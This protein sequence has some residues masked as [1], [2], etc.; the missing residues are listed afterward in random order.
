MEAVRKRRPIWKIVLSFLGILA[1]TLIVFLIWLARLSE[2]RWHDMERRVQE[3]KAEYQARI[4]PRPVLR[5][6][7]TPGN[8]WDDY[9]PAIHKLK[10]IHREIPT[11]HE[12]VSRGKNAD[13]TAVESLLKVHGGL[14]DQLRKGAGR[15]EGQFGY[16]FEGVGFSWARFWS[17][18][19]HSLGHLAHLSICQTRLLGEAGKLHE[20]IALLLDVAQYARDLGENSPLN[21]LRDSRFNLSLLFEE[22]R[23]QLSPRIFPAEEAGFLKCGLEILDRFLPRASGMLHCQMIV[24]GAFLLSENQSFVEEL[25]IPFM[26]RMQSSYAF[27]ECIQLLS[28]LAEEESPWLEFQESHRRILRKAEK[29]WNPILP[30][31][32]PPLHTWTELREQRTQLRLLRLAATYRTTGQIPELEDPFGTKL[33]HAESGDKLR[34]WSVGPDGVDDS[35]KGAWKAAATGDILLEIER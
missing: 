6:V 31:F 15:T 34:F 17:P 12:Y 25:P 30:I 18:E 21:A 33:L 28:Q 23:E 13:R 1:G 32:I 35:G 24:M 2:R 9:L 19:S 4:A 11:L 8:A 26:T 22:L 7:A 3:M 29:S 10:G 14:L 5:G 20:A 16:E 27:F